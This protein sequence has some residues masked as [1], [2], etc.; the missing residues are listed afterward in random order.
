MGCLYQL[1]SVFIQ[2]GKTIFCPTTSPIVSLQWWQLPP[3]E[4][5]SLLVL[6]SSGWHST[7]VGFHRIYIE[8]QI[9]KKQRTDKISSILRFPLKII[10]IYRTSGK[11]WNRQVLQ[12]KLEELSRLAKWRTVSLPIKEST[13]VY[14]KYQTLL[15]FS[16][17]SYLCFVSLV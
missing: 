8:V 4:I 3:A 15:I 16:Q 11:N 17:N 1:Y 10:E 2:Q 14:L 5:L 7:Q 12:R 9:K 6:S 13:F